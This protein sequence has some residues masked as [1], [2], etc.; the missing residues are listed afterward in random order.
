MKPESRLKPNG[1]PNPSRPR[2]AARVKHPDRPKIMLV[3]RLLLSDQIWSEGDVVV[4]EAGRAIH[5]RR[6]FSPRV[7][8]ML[9]LGHI[10]FTRC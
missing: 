9:Q 3:S 7:D 5:L 4:V 10:P 6:G 2:S 8:P 1:S